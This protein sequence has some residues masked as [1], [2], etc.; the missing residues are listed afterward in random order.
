MNKTVCSICSANLA[1]WWGASGSNLKVDDDDN[2]DDDD[3]DDDVEEDDDDD[4]DDM[5]LPRTEKGSLRSAPLS[6]VGVNKACEDND[7]DDVLLEGE[8][9]SEEVDDVVVVFKTSRE[10][11]RR[12]SGRYRDGITTLA[13]LTLVLLK[14][15]LILPLVLL[16]MLVLALFTASN[17]ERRNKE[18]LDIRPSLLSSSSSSSPASAASIISSNKSASEDVCS[19]SCADKKV[20]LDELRTAPACC[21]SSL[22]ASSLRDISW[23]SRI[24]SSSSNWSM[25]FIRGSKMVER[26]EVVKEEEEEEGGLEGKWGS[27]RRDIPRTPRLLPLICLSD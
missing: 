20:A 1:C 2:D 19:S 16:V 9:R 26:K 18:G 4:D 21:L 25:G 8:N 22:S 15:A 3:D 10:D 6:D 23:A 27:G 24:I 5:K 13:T 11:P 14:S 17:G 7:C 12:R